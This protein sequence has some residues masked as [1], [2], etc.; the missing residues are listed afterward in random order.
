MK[1]NYIL[2]FILAVLMFATI[3]AKA[4]VHMVDVADFSFTPSTL[5]VVVGDTVQWMWVSGT[6]TTTSTAVPAGALTWNN[7]INSSNSFFNYKVLVPGSYSYDCSIHPTLMTGTFTATLTGIQEIS[8]VSFFGLTNTN[9]EVTVKVE[10]NAPS[11]VNIQLFDMLGK[12]Q[13]TLKSSVQNAGTYSETFSFG[14]LPKGMYMIQ[15]IAD[16]RRITRRIIFE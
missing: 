11:M 4:T 7:N 6:H 13:R 5:N 14:D 16:N 2:N 9:N 8:N 3:S 15:L 12:Y 10:L 1:K